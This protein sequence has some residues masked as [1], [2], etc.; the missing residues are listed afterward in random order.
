MLHA[1]A[2]PVLLSP[3]VW[4]AALPWLPRASLGRGLHPEAQHLALTLIVGI[5]R[6]QHFKVKGQLQ[7][8][9]SPASVS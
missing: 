2:L 8:Q 5:Q 6:D 9:L 1:P 7:P 3:A 4:G